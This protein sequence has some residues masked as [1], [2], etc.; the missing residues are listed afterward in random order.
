M[1]VTTRHQL[2]SLS[3]PNAISEGGPSEDTLLRT[4]QESDDDDDP[5][6][7][8]FAVLS[9]SEEDESVWDEPESGAPEEESG[10][11][12]SDHPEVDDDYEGTFNTIKGYMPC[13]LRTQ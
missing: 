7:G 2:R 4:M 9:S 13:K 5:M 12:E 3:H 10:P 8:S 1:P 6:D 11:E